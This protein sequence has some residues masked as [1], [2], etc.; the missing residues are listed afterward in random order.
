MPFPKKVTIYNFSTIIHPEFVIRRARSEHERIPLFDRL[1]IKTDDL[2]YP[3][4]YNSCN[5]PPGRP[6][7]CHPDT[8]FSD[9]P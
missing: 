7:C 2:L 8:Q 4:R 6:A 5:Q 1:P 9:S 3:N